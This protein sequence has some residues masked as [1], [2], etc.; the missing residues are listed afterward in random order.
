MFKVNVLKPK[1]VVANKHK[2]NVLQ[3]LKNTNINIRTTLYRKE[4]KQ[5]G[6][7]VWQL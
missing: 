3:T 4:S 6:F 7:S 2:E 5:L 1:I